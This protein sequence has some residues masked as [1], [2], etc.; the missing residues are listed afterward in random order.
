MK[1]DNGIQLAVTGDG[2]NA[3]ENQIKG[4]RYFTIMIFL[5][6]FINLID[7]NRFIQVSLETFPP[8]QYYNRKFLVKAASIIFKVVKNFLFK[9][10]SF[11]HIEMMMKK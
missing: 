11:S 8:K 3:V 10:S 4:R 6:N 7:L 1:G 9:K 5:H 2:R